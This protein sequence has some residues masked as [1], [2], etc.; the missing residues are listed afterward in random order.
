MMTVEYERFQF[1][2]AP[3]TGSTWFLKAASI[4]GLGD[5]SKSKV[6]IPFPDDN[7]K[8]LRVSMVRRPVD[9]MASYWASI[10]PG[11][12]G[13]H[14]IDA[15]GTYQW[16]DKD[17]AGYTSRSGVIQNFDDF[18]RHYLKYMPGQYGR[19][20]NHYQSDNVIRIED[21]PWCF[22]EFVE[23][24]K[25][26]SPHQIESLRNL[27]K[28]NSSKHLPVWNKKLRRKVIEAEEEIYDRYEYF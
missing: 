28:Q 10:Y 3:R 22:I 7:S 16:G 8:T 4:S 20:I 6:H 27:N 13:I 9:W 1:A 18:V 2:S 26:L 21:T 12:V 11:S 24:F 25:S 14:H 17:S 15:L 19:I 5:G 23:G